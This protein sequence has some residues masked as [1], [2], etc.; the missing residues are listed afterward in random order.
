M[1]IQFYTRRGCELCDEAE[2]MLRLVAEDYPLEW[3]TINIEEDDEIHEKYML[4]IP[5]IEQDG[6][7]LAYG[8]IGYIDILELIEN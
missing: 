4:M 7:V 2:R 6:Q 5:V 8:N 3:Q 1:Q